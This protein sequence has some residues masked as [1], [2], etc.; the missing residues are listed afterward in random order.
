M[1]KIS[2]IFDRNWETNRKVNEKLIV[3]FNFEEAIATEKLDGM[4]VR[5][6][7][8]KGTVVRVEKRRN[9][10]KIQK[11]MGITEPWYIDAQQEAKEDRWIFDAVSNTDFTQV[12]DGEWSGEALGP[13]I[14]GNPL[15]LIEH[16]IFLFSLPE[17][18]EKIILKEVPFSFDQLKDF[19]AN[20]KSII[21]N[22]ALI[23]GIVWHHPN[24][25]MVKIKRKD[26]GL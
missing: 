26:F 8:R 24:G 16:Q 5:V 20:Q 18:R 21:G 22:D 2:T 17:W 19:L 6:T 1:R 4:N 14:Q 7:I 15:N 3:D 10:N 9:P 11:Q 23:E 12:P 25:E 13:K